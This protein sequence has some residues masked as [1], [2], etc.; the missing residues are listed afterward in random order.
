[1]KDYTVTNPQFSDTIQIPETTDTNH[2]DNINHAPLQIYENTMVL[3]NG[4]LPADYVEGNAY[5]V[6]DYVLHNG[7]VYRAVEEIEEGSTWE[8]ASS[9]VVEANLYEDSGSNGAITEEIKSSSEASVEEA[10][11]YTDAQIEKHMPIVFTVELPASGWSGLTQTVEDDR[12]I[13]DGY[14]YITSPDDTSYDDYQ[15][16]HAQGVEIAGQMIFVCTVDEPPEVD[17]S[18]NV[19]R[20]EVT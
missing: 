19:L 1:M 9:K 11:A 13:V 10:N 20:M 7:T 15:D 3:K 17:L 6:G 18:V 12:F 4:A 16:V 5:S 8:D 2:A 14:A